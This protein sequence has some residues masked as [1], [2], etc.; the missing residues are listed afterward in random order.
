MQRIEKIYEMRK[1]TYEGVRI[2]INIRYTLIY[3]YV[4]RMAVL[5]DIDESSVENRTKSKC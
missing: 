2:P 3:T 4:N 5:S 1:I